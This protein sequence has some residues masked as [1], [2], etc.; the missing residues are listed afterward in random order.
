[1]PD[2]AT[3]ARR[4]P[5]RGGSRL[6]PFWR[7]F[8]DDP[9]RML[10]NAVRE[11]GDVVQFVMGPVRIYLV[12]HPDHVQRL[13]VDNARN[14]DKRTR[15][16]DTLRAFL[17]NGLLTSEGEFWKR[18]RRIAQPA[19]HRQR[20]AG[21]GETMVKYTADLVDR[22]TREQS[23]G[24]TID[25]HADMTSLTL[26]IVS[27]TLLS[28]QVHGASG[29][30]EAV[31]R[32]NGMARDVMTNP[33]HPPL[34]IPTPRNREFRRL[35]ERVDAVV[36][37]IIDDRRRTGKDED[38]LLSMLMNAS[39]A[40]TGERMTDSQLRDEIMTM[41]LAGHETT[42]NALSWS[43][44]LLS[45]HPTVRRRMQAELDEVLGGRLP[46]VDDLAAL[47][48]TRCVVQETLRLY[49]PAWSIGRRSIGEDTF[50][51]YRIR[52]G[53]LVIAAP[54]VTHRHPRFWP[55]PEGFDPDRFADDAPK[56]PRYAYF[57]FGGG[58]RLCI[59]NNFA[60]M[61]AQLVLA[62][63]AQRFDADLVPGA[64]VEPAAYITLRP[65]DGLPMTL[66]PRSA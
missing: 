56:R 59:G 42:A 30:G 62:T 39:D 14:Y 2:T 13:F 6:Q 17:G 38:D 61:E 60:L 3:P 32:M 54:W 64:K 23:L 18:Q 26:R 36:N 43:L 40:E 20:I 66:R 46:T 49:P 47:T 25:A 1:M 10:T 5:P 55:N 45:T 28:A 7:V 48:Y 22:W 58:S 19:F 44:Y 16:Y 4:E 57:P 8:R 50:G 21:F 63:L 34:W 31:E 35:G 15:G 24:R 33:F 11:H 51:G 37:G 12:A 53:C 52:S 65:R 29:I 41:F 9:L 27:K